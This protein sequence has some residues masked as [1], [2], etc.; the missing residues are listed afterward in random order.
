MKSPCSAE[1][2]ISGKYFEGRVRCFD[3]ARCGIGIVSGDELPY[4]P[5]FVLNI[6]A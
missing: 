1:V 2:G 3:Y 4:L 5:K 6:G